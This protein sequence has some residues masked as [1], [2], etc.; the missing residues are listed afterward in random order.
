MYIY[1][2]LHMYIQCADIDIDI[3]VHLSIHTLYICVVLYIIEDDAY[4]NCVF[5]YSSGI[6]RWD[7]MDTNTRSHREILIQH[8]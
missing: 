6:E 3:S 5:Y 8:H 1:T 2:H 4:K 7:K